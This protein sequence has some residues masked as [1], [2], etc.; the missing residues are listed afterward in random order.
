M[1]AAIGFVTRILRASFLIVAVHRRVGAGHATR[2][3]ASVDGAGVLVVAGR[4]GLD[5]RAHA[6]CATHVALGGLISVIAR[7]TS[8]GSMLAA[9]IGTTRVL[10]AAVH[11]V[12][13]LRDGA[14]HA[15]TTR[16]LV[17]TLAHVAVLAGR[18]IVQVLT[19]TAR[20]VTRVGGARVIV[21]ALL[22]LMLAAARRIARVGRARITIVAVL[23]RRAGHTG[24]GRT[25]VS[26]RARIAIVARQEI[27]D[28]LTAVTDLQRITS[29]GG[30]V[31]AVAAICRAGARTHAANTEISGRAF[32]AIIARLAVPP[33][34]VG[35]RA[36]RVDDVDGAGVLVVA[37]R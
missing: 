19:Q 21:P 35:A 22:S 5:A 37:G 10:R 15:G 8:L 24:P 32:V 1:D 31:V 36:V 34:G 28:V 17:S 11:V 29:V 25:F 13:V 26:R 9:D 33:L 4:D 14:A 3:I 20:R 18:G 12:A 23:L 16:T 30:A 2:R 27:I 6:I 7:S